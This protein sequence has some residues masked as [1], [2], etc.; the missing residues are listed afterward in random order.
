MFILMISLKCLVFFPVFS[1][2]K[3]TFLSDLEAS[4]TYD[5]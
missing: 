1:F 4:D 5:S 3:D 2:K